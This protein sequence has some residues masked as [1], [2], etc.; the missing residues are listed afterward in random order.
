V[1]LGGAVNDT[2]VVAE[3]DALGPDGYTQISEGG[4]KIHDLFHASASCNK[5]G[6]VGCGFH[7]GLLLG[8]PVY[9]TLVQEMQYTGDGSAGQHTMV[10]VGVNVVR[11]SDELSQWFRGVRG[12]A[13]G[14]I[15]IDG[16]LPVI[17]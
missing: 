12:N 17:L 15:A 8:E 2:F 5:L 1:D 16:P 4:A 9:W 6:T 11:Q 13:F 7:G 3:H 10:E 14:D